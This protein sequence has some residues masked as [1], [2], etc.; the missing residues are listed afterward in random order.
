VFDRTSAR[1]VRRVVFVELAVFGELAVMPRPVSRRAAG[2]RVRA[3]DEET[4]PRRAVPELPRGAVA[5]AVAPRELP[6]RAVPR[7]GLV[8]LAPPARG[9]DRGPGEERGAVRAV[10]VRGAL[11]RE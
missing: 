5:R 9:E 7:D 3:P 10:L 4:M 1:V 8:R 2:V 6:A 11:G